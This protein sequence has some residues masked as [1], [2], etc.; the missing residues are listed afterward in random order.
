MP[1][2]MLIIG[3][4]FN[5][6]R[7]AM[8][9]DERLLGIR[10]P[11]RWDLFLVSA[12]V[13]GGIVFLNTWDL[14]V[15][16]SLLVGA[17]LVRQVMQKGWSWSR[18]GEV[19]KL[20]IPM[21][22]LSFVLYLPF[23]ISFQSQAGGILPNVYYPTRGLYLWIMFGTLFIPIFL[24]FGWLLRKRVKADWGWSGI[25]IGG[26]VALLAAM[27]IS[28]ALGIARTEFGQQ[29]IAAQGFS[30]ASGLLGAALRQRLTYGVTLLTLTALLVTGLAFLI[31]Q[32]KL[33][34]DDETGL[35]ANPIG[36][37]LLMVVLGGLMVLAPEFVYLRDNFGTRMNTVF[38]FYYQAWMLWSLAAAFASVILLR[39]GS[40]CSRIVIVLF[41]I[42]GLVYPVFAYPDKTNDFQ[43]A[44]GYTLDASAYLAAY[45]PG[46]AA[47]ID[48][49]SQQPAGTVAEA[50]GGQYSSYARV[51]TLSGQP[52]VLGWPGHEGQWRGGYTEVGNRETD[53]RTLYE[54]PDWQTALDI[55]Q[56]Y[57]IRY[58]YIGSLEL[59]TYAVDPYKF[60]QNLEVGFSDA[61]VQVFVV[62]DTLLN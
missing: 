37:V 30:S 23:L 44:N 13:V 32:M 20:A 60:E 61:G 11:F 21:G 18:L 27:V 14:P 7:G 6:Y 34:D 36:F 40:W 2:V 59:N 38:K 29:L 56:R 16:F 53:I 58:L 22:V 43:S 17:F 31:G 50:V 15:Y 1:F 33:K 25:I 19:L 10:V 28:L 8:D 55:I 46:E 9:S 12:I 39:K 4:A 62:P 48:W 35:E 57:G 3:L 49:L 52:T 5:I 54:A 45:Q 24:F 42:M 47:A 41:V 51:A 26:L